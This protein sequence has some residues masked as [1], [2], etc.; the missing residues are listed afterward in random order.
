MQDT[1]F[2]CPECGSTE[3]GS[4]IHVSTNFREEDAWSGVLHII[5]CA[6][7]RYNIPAHLGELWNDITPE[8]ARQEW[9]STY[10]EDSLRRFKW[11]F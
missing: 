8:E 10:R 11:A 1:P 9:H 2:L 7:C 3:P 4:N 5:V 6:Q